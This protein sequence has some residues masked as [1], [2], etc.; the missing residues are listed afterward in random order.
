MQQFGIELG[1]YNMF[2]FDYFPVPALQS[3]HVA[4]LSNLLV[5]AV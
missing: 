5:E 1:K 4:K 3:S 2:S